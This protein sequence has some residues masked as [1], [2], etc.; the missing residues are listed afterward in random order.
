MISHLWRN[1][2]RRQ[3]SGS[4]YQYYDAIVD[5]GGDGDYT[6]LQDADDEL[7]SGAYF[8]LVKS[9]SYS[10]LAV[11]TNNVMIHFEPG[12]T[13][14]GDIDLS[15]SNI[16]LVFSSGCSGVDIDITGN[17]NSVKMKNGCSFNRVQWGSS[18]NT[19]Y[20]NGGGIGTVLTEDS[21]NAIQLDEDCIAEYASANASSGT[22][23]VD[24]VD[25]RAICN[26]I[27][28]DAAASNGVQNTN[29]SGD[30]VLIINT[31]VKAATGN[32][33]DFN[34]PRF[35]MV[36]NILNDTVDINGLGDDSIFAGNVIDGACTQNADADDQCWTANR[37]DTTIPSEAS[38]IYSNNNNDPF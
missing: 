19:G 20:F 6:T 38:S 37:I 7:D 25:G 15:G 14:S 9:G 24:L 29:A 12:T 34:A 35:R 23:G 5:A 18:S 4:L 27:N 3:P 10:T 33:G 2:V 13:L 8:L 17:N 36:A 16:S 21:S 1:R 28:V 32:A 31:I 22:N 26:G 11:S 30:E